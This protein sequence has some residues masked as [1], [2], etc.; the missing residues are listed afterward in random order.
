M[1]TKFKTTLLSSL[2]IL[3]LGGLLSGCDAPMTKDLPPESDHQQI[4]IQTAQHINGKMALKLDIIQVYDKQIFENLKTLDANA[5]RDKKTQ[6][7]FDNPDAISVWSFDF[8]DGQSK[9]YQLPTAR[10]Y[11]GI[12]IYLHFIDSAENRVVI[13]RQMKHMRLQIEEGRF[14]MAKDDHVHNFEHLSVGGN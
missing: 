6:I 14:T 2:M 9:S 12:I 4:T 13:P 7:L 11:W 10:N 1:K 3:I 8:I 5:F